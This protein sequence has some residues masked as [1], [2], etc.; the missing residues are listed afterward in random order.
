MLSDSQQSAG[1]VCPSPGHD[2]IRH[3][4]RI[5]FRKGG[6]LRFLS[7]HD[8]MTC[9]ERMLRRADVPFH[10]SQGFHPKPRL[11][12]ALALG[13]GIVGCEEVVELEL[14]ADVAA[15]DLHVRLTREAPP[16]LEILAVRRID[17]RA[18]AQVRTVTYRLELPSD[19][20]LASLPD[21]IA[22]LLAAPSC[23]VERLR[24]RKRQL[25]LRPYLR[26]LRLSA[27]AL[28]IDVWVTPTGGARPDEIAGLLGLGHLLSAGTFFERTHLEITDEIAV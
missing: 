26:D 23:W 5:R 4:A 14:D 7:H 9:F 12:F 27:G 3:K 10:S 20:R 18:R 6:D 13:L 24:P 15:D 16:G 22:A 25:D 2:P 8:L 21:R 28:E 11:V 1:A 19:D 17:P